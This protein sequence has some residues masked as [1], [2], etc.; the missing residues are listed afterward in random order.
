MCGF[1]GLTTAIST[2]TNNATP[3]PAF[4]WTQKALFSNMAEPQPILVPDRP[5]GI[6]WIRRNDAHTLG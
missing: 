2:P 1:N 4:D 3:V 6:L 5:L